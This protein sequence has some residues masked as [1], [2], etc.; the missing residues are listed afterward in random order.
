M[1]PRYV[2]WN[3]HLISGLHEKLTSPEDALEGLIYLCETYGVNTFC[4]MPVFTPFVQTASHF[5]LKRDRSLERI[6]N[7]Y[8]ERLENGYHLNSKDQRLKHIKIMKSTCVALEPGCHEIKDLHRLTVPFCGL[9]YLPIRLPITEFHDSIDLEINRLLYRTGFH[10]W[11]VSFD[12]A[13]T[14]YPPE[15]IQK[16]MRIKNSV[17]QFNYRSLENPSIRAI[18]QALLDQNA[19]VLFGTSLDCPAKAYHYDVSYYASLVEKYFPK[20]SQYRLMRYYTRIPSSHPKT[21]LI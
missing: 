4:M 15:I 18:I 3:S 9:D 11:F 19:P 5:I 1:I 8:R 20:K 7:A 21:L 17:F 13:C 14:L 16:L 2:D 10:L 6:Q 12:V